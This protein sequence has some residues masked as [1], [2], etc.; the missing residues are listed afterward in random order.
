MCKFR[1]KWPRYGYPRVIVSE[2]VP[3]FDTY[4]YLGTT[5]NVAE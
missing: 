4:V 1:V 5:N 2:N 3:I